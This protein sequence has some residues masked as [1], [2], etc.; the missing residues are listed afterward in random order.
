MLECEHQFRP[1]GGKVAP[2]TRTASLHDDWIP[3]GHRWHWKVAVGRYEIACEVNLFK[4][5]D[6]DESSVGLVSDNSFIP[7]TCPKLHTQF[8]D[9]VRALIPNFPRRKLCVPKKPRFGIIPR[10]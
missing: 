3:L 4:P 8:H 7:P 6:I 5:L 1:P 9:L 10:G 2:F